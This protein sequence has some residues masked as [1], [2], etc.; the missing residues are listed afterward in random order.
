MNNLHFLL[1][2][3][4]I[5]QNKQIIAKLIKIKEHFDLCDILR[6]R[7]PDSKQ[8]NFRQ[9]YASS[10]IRRRLDYFFTSNSPEDMTTHANFFAALSTDHSPVTISISKKKLQP[11]SQFLEIRQFFA[12]RPKLC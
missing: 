7:N 6:L 1:D 4:G 2:S 12:F 3:L 10:F 9:K 11:W 5:H 8:F